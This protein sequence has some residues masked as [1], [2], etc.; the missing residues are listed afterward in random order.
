MILSGQLEVAFGLSQ[1][2]AKEETT[3]GNYFVSNYPP[4]SFWNPETGPQA[5]E[6]LDRPPRPGRRSASTYISLSAGNA[7]TSVTSR[8]IPIK[9]P[10]RS[11]AIWMPWF[12]N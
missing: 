3:A 4:Y 6:A 9:T 12:A 7:A 11:I 1:V 2:S 8:S 10:P 5:H